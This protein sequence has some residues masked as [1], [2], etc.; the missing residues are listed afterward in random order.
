[1]HMRI[2]HPR[3]QILMTA[4]P[5]HAPLQLTAGMSVSVRGFGCCPTGSVTGCAP[6]ADSPAQ[7]APSPYA[8]VL[9]CAASGPPSL[10]LGSLDV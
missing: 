1:M 10:S 2:T 8:D 3:L 4:T 5:N 9:P 6:A 7:P